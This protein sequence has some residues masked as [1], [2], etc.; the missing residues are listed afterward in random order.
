MNERDILPPLMQRPASPRDLIGALYVRGGVSPGSGFD[1]FTLMAYVRWHWFGRLTPL[2]VMPA[3]KLATPALCALM[4]RRALGRAEDPA[5]PWKRV[6][7]AP[8]CA[9]ALGRSKLGRLHHCGVWWED[10]VLHAL[11]TAGVVWT[12]ADRIGALYSRVEC[13]ELWQY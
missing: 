6:T 11:D 13:F 2:G 8:G 10:G 12:P 5:A 4:I 9:V 7:P 3:R 1:C